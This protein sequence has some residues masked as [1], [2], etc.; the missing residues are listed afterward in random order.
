MTHLPSS[1]T[2]AGA[3]E[4]AA[5][6]RR[7]GATG[8]AAHQPPAPLQ[9]LR[10]PQHAAQRPG[11]QRSSKHESAPAATAAALPVPVR[12]QAG[13]R[14]AAGAVAGEAA[15]GQA[16]RDSSDAEDDVPLVQVGWLRGWAGA[17]SVHWVA[18]CGMRG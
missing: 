10:S 1:A 4:A 6:K 16:G 3:A 15:L 12:V 5:K 17:G 11:G 9:Q 13:A 8:A 2:C 18:A 7:L 14:R